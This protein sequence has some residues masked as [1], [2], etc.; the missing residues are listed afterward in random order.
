[1]PKATEVL[2]HH[3]AES[4][5]RLRDLEARGAHWVKVGEERAYREALIDCLKTLGAYMPTDPVWTLADFQEEAK[6]TITHP[7]KTPEQHLS[8][9]ALGL[10]GEAGE[11]ADLIKKHQLHDHRLDMDKAREELGDV[12]WYVAAL[13]AQLGLT[14]DQVAEANSRK[15]AL[16]YPEAFDPARSQNRGG[17]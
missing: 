5:R 3:L 7:G 16:R 1:M 10:A 17:Q 11:F 4:E 9:F 12:L 8:G 6:R 2:A 14:L 13:A 15:R